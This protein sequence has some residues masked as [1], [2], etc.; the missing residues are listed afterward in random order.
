V[1]EPQFIEQLTTADIS[2]FITS[3]MA[4]R[5]LAP[6]NANHY[7]SIL[8]RLF[9]W[10]A[11]HRGLKL[12]GSVNPALKVEKVREPAPEITFLTL[13]QIEQQ[14]EVLKDSPRFQAAV[15]TYIF[16]G[17]GREELLWLTRF[18]AF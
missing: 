10:A 8:G 3:R 12:P 17:L 15:A 1:L 18:A 9:T 14:L 2:A 11:D 5:G 13:E 6:K 7:R 4:S 16:A